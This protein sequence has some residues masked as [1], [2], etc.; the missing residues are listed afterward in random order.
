MPGKCLDQAARLPSGRVEWWQQSARHRHG[1]PVLREGRK[2]ANIHGNSGFIWGIP[3]Y[4]KMD[5]FDKGEAL[6][7]AQMETR[8]AFPARRFWAAFEITGSSD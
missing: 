6:R 7:L 3:V 4:Q 2:T 5:K 1:T 8:K